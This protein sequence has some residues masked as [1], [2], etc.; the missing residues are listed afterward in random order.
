[1]NENE[2]DYSAKGHDPNAEPSSPYG[3]RHGSSPCGT[4]HPTLRGR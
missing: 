2:E 1:M 4:R 3:T